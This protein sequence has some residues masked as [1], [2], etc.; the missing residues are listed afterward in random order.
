[1]EYFLPRIP[2]RHYSTHI[3]YTDSMRLL[4]FFVI[5]TLT[6]LRFKKLMRR[7]DIHSPNALGYRGWVNDEWAESHIEKGQRLGQVIVSRLPIKEH[8]FE[9]FTNPNFEVVWEDGSIAHSHDKGRTKC[10][11]LLGDGH[12]ISVHTLH[13]IP[14]RRFKVEVKSVEAKAVLAVNTSVR[15]KKGDCCR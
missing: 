15:V 12:S 1:M 10:T 4:S 14:F 8:D 3:E 5:R 11:V 7:L 2:I 9:W 13:T 6:L